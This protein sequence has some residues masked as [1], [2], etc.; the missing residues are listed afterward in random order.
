VNGEWS[1]A[2]EVIFKRMTR[3]TQNSFSV[4][5]RVLKNELMKASQK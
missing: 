4:A 1:M 5:A 2:G 3:S